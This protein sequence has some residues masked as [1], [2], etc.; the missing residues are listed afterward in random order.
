MSEK[1]ELRPWLCH[2][3]V[4]Q[5][6]ENHSTSL[7]EPLKVHRRDYAGDALSTQSS[8]VLL[9]SNENP[10]LS[11]DLGQI[12]G[13]LEDLSLPSCTMGPWD[14]MAQAGPR[15]QLREP[16]HLA[17]QTPGCTAQLPSPSLLEAVGSHGVGGAHHAQEVVLAHHV[18][19]PELHPQW[20]WGPW[21]LRKLQHLVPVWEAGLLNG[22]GG[23]RREG[24]LRRARRDARPPGAHTTTH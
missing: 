24:G 10:G 12:P 23:G 19:V 18:P 13:P 7:H 3:L 4:I 9:P 6:W 1:P 5:P 14:P 16:S 17:F 11:R 2:L 20:G 8:W 21:Q 22:L 15:G